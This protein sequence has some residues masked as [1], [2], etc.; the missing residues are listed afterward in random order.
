M[1]HPRRLAR[2]VACA[3]ALAWVVVFNRS[4]RAEVDFSFTFFDVEV[5]AGVG[6]DDPVLGADRR[7]AVEGAAAAIGARIGQDAVV[8]IGVAPSEM[9][10]TGPIGIASAEFLDATPGVR[11]GEVY[12]R[13]VLGEPD[14]TPDLLDAG[15]AF[16]FGYVTQLSGEPAAGVSYFPDVVRHE[17]THALGFGSFLRADGTGLGGVS[18]DAYTRFDSFLTTDGGPNPGLEV[19]DAAGA[20]LLDAPTFAFAFASG[21]VFDG[22][23]TRAANGGAALKLFFSD[24]THSGDAADVMFPSPAVGYVRDDWSALDVA[25]LTDLGYEIVPEPSAGWLLA[26]AAAGLGCVRPRRRR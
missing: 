16:D 7:A 13:I 17:L 3:A 19:I 9:D 25:V 4:A 5:G 15:M 2:G 14:T 24:P 6:F 26:A 22:P 11:D 8:E 21:L 10:G 12:R 23:A 1:K 18:P 20:L